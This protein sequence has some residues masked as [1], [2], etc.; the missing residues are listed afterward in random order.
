MQEHCLAAKLKA[1]PMATEH[2]QT[3]AKTTRTVRVT[4]VVV[5]VLWISASSLIPRIL[6]KSTGQASNIL[7]HTDPQHLVPR[8]RE[9]HAIAAMFHLNNELAA[10]FPVLNGQI[11]EGWQAHYKRPVHIN[12]ILQPLSTG[13]NSYEEEEIEWLQKTVR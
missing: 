3:K 11:N 5:I 9:V 1:N 4:I 6:W 10:K 8:F 13:E 12:D 7:S 2:M